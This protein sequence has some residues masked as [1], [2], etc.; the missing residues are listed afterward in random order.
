M[1]KSLKA[2]VLLIVFLV[3]FIPLASNNPDGLEKVSQ[4]LGV[5][6][7]KVFWEGLMTDY[8]VLFIGNSYVSTLV[9][10]IIG[11]ILVFCAALALNKT[12][13]PKN[14]KPVKEK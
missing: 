3:V 8:S 11:T 13:K 9:S 6:E 12:L 7:Q 4:G 10:G 14:V 2:I 5:K 1:K